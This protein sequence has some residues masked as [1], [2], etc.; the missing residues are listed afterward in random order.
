MGTGIGG[1]MVLD[2]RLIR[3]VNRLAG[4]AGWFALTEAVELAEPV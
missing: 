2:G 4:A 3:G 1:G